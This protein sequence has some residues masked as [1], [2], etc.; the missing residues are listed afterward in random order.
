MLDV[1]Q[2][3]NSTGAARVPYLKYSYA[4]NLSQTS[5]YD[6]AESIS[7]IISAD[8]LISQMQNVPQI[9]NNYRRCAYNLTDDFITVPIISDFD[10]SGE[11]YSALFHELIHSTGHPSRLNRIS[12]HESKEQYC[13]EELIAELGSSYLCAMCGIS[14]S[15]LENQ[16][17]YLHGWM[18]KIGSDSNILIRASV[19]TKKAID[20]LLNS[21]INES[22]LQSLDS[23]E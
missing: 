22:S 14:N 21:S 1:D 20:L 10:T 15:V 9:K 23:K 4:F 5:L 2:G 18:S 8:E 3:E 19:Q 16:A 12:L 6:S 7:R 17:A 11:Y 13:E